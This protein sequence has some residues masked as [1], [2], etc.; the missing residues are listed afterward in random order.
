MFDQQLYVAAKLAE[1]DVRRRRI[2]VPPP[3]K[4]RVARPRTDARARD[5]T[6]PSD[7]GV[8]ARM[9]LRWVR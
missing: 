8:R 5:D 1:L 3:R 4:V 7:R 6:A 9:L 2:P